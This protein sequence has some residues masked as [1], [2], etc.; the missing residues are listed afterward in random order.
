[1]RALLR[2]YHLLEMPEAWNQHAFD[3]HVHDANTKGRKSPTHLVM[4]AWIKGIRFL[5]VVYYNT[6]DPEAARELLRAARIMG[7]T[8]RIGIEFRAAFKDKL[9]EFTWSPLNTETSKTF[10]EL[11]R[12]KDVAAVLTAHAPVNAWMR[13]HVLLLL[14]AWN[15]RHAP[16]LAARWGLETPPPL[17][18]AAFLAYVGQRQPSSLHLAEYIYRSGAPCAGK[19]RGNR[20]RPGRGHRPPPAAATAGPPGPAGQSGAR[21]PARRLAR[22]E[23]NPGIVFPLRPHP[24]L[25]TILRQTPE[26]LLESLVPLHPCQMILNL[27][28]LTAQDV[29][30]LLWRCQGRITTWSSSICGNGTKA[31]CAT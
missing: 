12:R 29:L 13:S 4:D 24:T 20:R 16:A 9:I 6:V 8:V 28:D 22:P 17:D 21:R 5:T 27:A 3:H 26:E 1:M 10:T 7:I 2:R 30:E 11:I 18:E 14:R 23:T 19:A 31:S 25:P 15:Q